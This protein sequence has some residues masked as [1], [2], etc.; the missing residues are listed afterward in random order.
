MF[1]RRLLLGTVAV[2]LLAALVIVPV[3]AAHADFLMNFVSAS[4]TCQEGTFTFYVNVPA[5]PALSYVQ[6]AVPP[7]TIVEAVDSQGTLLGT[8]EYFILFIEVGGL[9]QGTIVYSQTPVGSVTFRLYHG[10]V[11]TSPG[12]EGAAQQPSQ[13]T[14]ADTITVEGDCA[15]APGCDQSMP[16]DGAV[17]GLFTS[18]A[19]AYATPG[20]LVVPSVTIQAGK[21]LYV[22]GQ[23]A[24]KRYYQVVLACTLLWVPKSTVGPDPE[25]LWHNTPL[26]TRIVQ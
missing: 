26:P 24:T 19:P 2:A 10:G 13:M 11:A 4:T 7:N 5:S 22:R 18:S 6:V 23:D 14:L 1:V 17:M 9:F 8:K 15:S 3:P 20:Q 16:L 25:P 12:A 21:T